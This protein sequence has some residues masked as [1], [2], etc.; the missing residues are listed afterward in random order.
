[1]ASI[2]F[3]PDS[4]WDGDTENIDRVGFENQKDPNSQ[5]WD[6]IAREVV[7]IET[8]MGVKAA[9]TANASGNVTAA[10][11]D[12]VVTKTVLTLNS[13]IPMTDN[14]AAGCHGS[15][16]VYD[17]P[18]A[19]IT[20]L[21]VVPDLTLTFGESGNVSPTASVNVAAGT[22]AAADDNEA[23][24]SAEADLSAVD[25]VSLTANV[26]SY[27][28]ILAAPVTFDGTATAKDAF[29]NIVVAAADASGDETCTVTGTLTITWVNGGDN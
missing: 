1:M 20:I 15:Q 13:P 3:Y 29:L 24:T 19:A 8:Q 21:S 25:A 18:E 12:G 9:G 6:R 27:G 17:F 22:E 14:G 2:A 10:E 16:K 5:D 11:T 28:S 4:I 26:G 23:L 7:A